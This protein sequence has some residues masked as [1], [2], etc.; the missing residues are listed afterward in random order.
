LPQEPLEFALIAPLKIQIGETKH[1]DARD[2]RRLKKWV[3]YF[4]D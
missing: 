4:L 3:K 2:E 1:I